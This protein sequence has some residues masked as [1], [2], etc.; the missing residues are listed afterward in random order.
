MYILGFDTSLDKTYVGISKDE[1]ILITKIIE[2]TDTNYHSAYLISTITSI[3]HEASI[4]PQDLD[5]I[6]VNVG[7]GSFTGIRACTTVARVMAQQLGIKT[8]GINS[9]EIL[10]KLNPVDKKTLVLLDARKNKTYIWDEELLGAINTDDVIEL[11]KNQDYSIIT[12]DAMYKIFSEYSK[13][14]K[15]YN[16]IEHNLGEIILQIANENV[17]N[18]TSWKN[19]APLYIQPP[20]IFC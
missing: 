7:P 10:S 15:S 9:L 20:P 5:L 13:D 18:A 16:V 6:A 3:L 1:K 2:N 8:I 17:L 11:V 19:L 14:I 12:D 4:T